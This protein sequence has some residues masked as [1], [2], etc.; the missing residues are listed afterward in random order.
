MKR[1]P[2]TRPVKAPRFDKALRLA[3]KK[4][5]SEGRTELVDTWKVPPECRGKTAA[6]PG[7]VMATPW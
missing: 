4:A 6:L 1:T 3:E 5:R 2:G 7:H